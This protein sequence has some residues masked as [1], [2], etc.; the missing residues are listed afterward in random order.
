MQTSLHIDEQNRTNRQADRQICRKVNRQI[1]MQKRERTDI[2]AEKS[3]D[4]QI[5]T[6]RHLKTDKG[7]TYKRTGR[8]TE[9]CRQTDRQACRKQTDIQID[10]NDREYDRASSRTPV[11]ANYNCYLLLTISSIYYS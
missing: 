3:A 8:H 7:L 2:H 6:D 4:T 11:E 1:G 9:T 5:R 10:E